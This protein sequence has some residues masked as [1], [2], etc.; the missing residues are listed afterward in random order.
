MN[1]RGLIQLHEGRVAHVYFDSLG[2]ATIGV[3]HLVDERKGGGLPELIID[4]L[5]DYDIELHTNELYSALP[6]V[7]ELDPVRQAVLIDMYF[8][9]RSNLLGFKETLRQFQAGNLDAAAAAMLDSLWAKQV[10]TRAIRLAEM[11]RS[12]QWPTD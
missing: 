1:V 2:L 4:A 3:G 9:L 7:Q 12:G 10:G 8:N 5:L 11:T 6:W